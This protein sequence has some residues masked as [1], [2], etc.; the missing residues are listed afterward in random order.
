MNKTVKKFSDYGATQTS[1]QA[2]L[3]LMSYPHFHGMLRLAVLTSLH[4]T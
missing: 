1:R 3:G 4:W 2:M